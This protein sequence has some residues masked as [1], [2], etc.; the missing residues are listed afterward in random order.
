MAN[1]G[2]SVDCGEGAGCIKVYLDS[3]VHLM[4]LH[5]TLQRKVSRK[6]GKGEVISKFSMISSCLWYSFFFVW[7]RKSHTCFQ[8]LL[9]HGISCVGNATMQKCFAIF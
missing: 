6:E 2:E 9:C 1:K 8:I 4:K 7:I 5:D 3:E